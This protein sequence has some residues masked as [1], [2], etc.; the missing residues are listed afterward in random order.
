MNNS[1]EFIDNNGHVLK[2]LD[3][4]GFEAIKAVGLQVAK[5]H[6]CMIAKE[7]DPPITMG[8]GTFVQIGK[9]LFVATAKHLFENSQE[10]ELVGIYWGE[11]DNRTSV[12]RGNVIL[13]EKLDLAAIPLP[14][15]IEARGLPLGCLQLD[16]AEVESDLFIVS[17]IPSKKCKIDQKSKTIDVGHFSLGLVALPRKSWPTNPE[18]AISTNVDLLFN[19]TRDL[20]INSD[21]TP[22]RQIDPRGL[23]GGGIWSVPMTFGGIWSPSKARLIA[24]QSS[25]ETYKWRYLRATKIEHWL[26]LTEFKKD[27][28]NEV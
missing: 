19:Y 3:Q 16:H 25:V 1:Y 13:D 27:K 20:A 6:T 14:N 26:P 23:S 24:V 10:D 9:H 12:I 7:C 15:H 11:Q 8:S 2:K 17:G 22:M 4:S 28:E 21:G 18:L 5:K